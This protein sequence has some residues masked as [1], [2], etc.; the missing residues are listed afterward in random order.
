MGSNYDKVTRVEVIDKFGRSYSNWNVDDIK[1]S[2]QD[3][4]K[5][6]KLFLTSI[7]LNSVEC[8]I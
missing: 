2:L 7:S 1:F 6:L 3:E 8:D 5:T 4:G